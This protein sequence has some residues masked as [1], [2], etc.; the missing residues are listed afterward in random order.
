MI[1]DMI[2]ILLNELFMDYLSTNLSSNH[3][4]NPNHNTQNLTIIDT[5]FL[6][7]EY[8]NYDNVKPSKI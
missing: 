8:F 6:E 5:H 7:L 2:L 1:L 4:L 3:L